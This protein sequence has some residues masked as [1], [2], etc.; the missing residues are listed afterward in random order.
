PVSGP[1][2][3]E[4]SVTPEADPAGPDEV[5]ADGAELETALPA[6]AVGATVAPLPPLAQPAAIATRGAHRI[7]HRLTD[8][9]FG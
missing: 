6:P 5:A 1:W 7:S 9:C 4:G 3:M 2:L 8:M